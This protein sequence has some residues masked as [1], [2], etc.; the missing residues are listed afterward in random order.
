MLSSY[1]FVELN[2]RTRLTFLFELK[3]L[4]YVMRPFSGLINLK[5]QQGAQQ[6]VGNIKRL[7]EAEI[8]NAREGRRRMARAGG[9]AG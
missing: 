6:V 4:D 9:S 3:R 2:Q 5:A 8:R 7:L 1:R